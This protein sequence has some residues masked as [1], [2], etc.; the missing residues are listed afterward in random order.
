MCAAMQNRLAWVAFLVVCFLVT[1]LTGLFASYSGVIPL[2]RAIH[3]SRALDNALTT[4][5]SA[6]ALSHLLGGDADLV[7]RGS[8]DLLARVARAREAVL[9]EGEREAA[10]VASRTRLMLGVITVLAAG[11]GAG[12]LLLAGRPAR[13]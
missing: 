5:G 8:G 3:R 4:D 10:A 1:G 12:I 7:A 9:S 6:A 2:E 13:D 11:L